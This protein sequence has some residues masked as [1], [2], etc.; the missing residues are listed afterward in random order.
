MTGDLRNDI[1]MCSE[2][3]CFIALGHKSDIFVPLFTAPI[4]IA[5]P[6]SNKNA[7]SMGFFHGNNTAQLALGLPFRYTGEIGIL[8][9]MDNSVQLIRYNPT[10]PNQIGGRIV[11]IPELASVIACNPETTSLP[12]TRKCV[13]FNFT[14]GS[15]FLEQDSDL[16]PP[17]ESAAPT[18][19][20]SL[21]VGML[22][23]HRVLVIISPFKTGYNSGAVVIYD[24]NPDSAPHLN[25][26]ANISNGNDEI[27]FTVGEYITFG[28]INQ[29]GL[30]DLIFSC[31]F[32]VT[33]NE[34]VAVIY[35]RNGD[36]EQYNK[37]KPDLFIGLASAKSSLL[38]I[39]S[40][41]DISGDGTDDIALHYSFPKGAAV[42]LSEYI[43]IN[44]SAR[45]WFKQLD[46]DS[47]DLFYIAANFDQVKL[48]P[49]ILGRSTG[50]VL[51]CES[52]PDKGA[53]ATFLFG[54]TDWKMGNFSDYASDLDSPFY[55]DYQNEFVIGAGQE[56]ALP[57]PK[58][59]KWAGNKVERVDVTM[60]VPD[61]LG[62]IELTGKVMKGV[63][64]LEAR[65]WK[66]S[67]IATE[68]NVTFTLDIFL[69]VVE[70]PEE[71]IVA[72]SDS[73]VFNVTV[74]DPTGGRFEYTATLEDGSPLPPF[75]Q[76]DPST[77]QL[78]GTIP[79]GEGPFVV[80]VTGSDPE[81]EDP[82]I[83]FS[84]DVVLS[85]GDGGDGGDNTGEI[86]GIIFGAF[87][88][89][90]LVIVITV[91]LLILIGLMVRKAYEAS[92]NS[93]TISTV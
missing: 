79:P 69:N 35:G 48:V 57:E 67:V 54:R 8:S 61:G 45:G 64:P 72:D 31:T 92:L 59:W 16:L 56:F 33:Q 28:D 2:Q 65:E 11:S 10:A 17:T 62:S 51:L 5:H 12:K 46:R 14:T 74:V 44:S 15:G 78:T 81:G 83:V 75:I 90:A 29:D 73:G 43:S 25:L 84:Y 80:I 7:C 50:D 27:P 70:L 26:K 36:I 91:I 68:E 85:A 41:V 9:C 34:G 71:E 49:S 1:A 66:F 6:I 93:K 19:G 77:L 82:D 20:E 39:S 21:E 18:W 52:G 30:G 4:P 32:I 87:F 55:S 24:I 13:V 86:I 40:G 88:C 76:F 42:F 3:S 38:G 47:D 22:G 23:D 37:F 53:R 63:A 58:V 60:D 89:V